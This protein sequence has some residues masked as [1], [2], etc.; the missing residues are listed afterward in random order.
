MLPYFTSR[1]SRSRPPVVVAGAVAVRIPPVEKDEEEKYKPIELPLVKRMLKELR[2]Y[3]RQYA[4]GISIGL[5]HVLLDML[6]PKF[7]QGIIDYCVAYRSGA[8]PGATDAVAIQHVVGIIAFWA[9]TFTGSVLLQ[10]ICII[11]M[12]RAGETVQFG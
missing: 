2:P 10:R 12:T 4:A 3:K 9:I 7:I 8:F 11:L 5:V 6:G 1:F